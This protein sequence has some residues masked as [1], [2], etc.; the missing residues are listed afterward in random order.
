MNYYIYNSCDQ[1]KSHDSM[2]LV[3]IFDEENL[4]KVIIE[5]VKSKEIE[6]DDR[7]EKEIEEMDIRTLNGLMTYGYVERIELNQRN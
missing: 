2:R 1:W 4:K 5:D 7:D 3:G 6:L